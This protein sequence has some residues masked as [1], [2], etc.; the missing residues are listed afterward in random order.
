VAWEVVPDSHKKVEG[1]A[2][3]DRFSF[4]ERGQLHGESLR[5]QSTY[6]SITITAK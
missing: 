6:G 4:V 1:R 5:T 3:A 2:V